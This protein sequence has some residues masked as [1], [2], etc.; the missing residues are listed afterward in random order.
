MLKSWGSRL[1]REDKD[2]KVIWKRQAR[3]LFCC[4]T[5]SIDL[6]T[7]YTYVEFQCRENLPSLLTE[8]IFTL[9]IVVWF[10]LEIYRR[11]KLF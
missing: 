8:C 7:E 1:S 4:L 6:A 5:S 11:C 2:A 9:G 10:D 3:P